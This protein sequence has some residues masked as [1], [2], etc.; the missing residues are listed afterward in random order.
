M[1]YMACIKGGADLFTRREFRFHWSEFV[2]NSFDG[3]FFSLAWA[4]YG[5]VT[6]ERPFLLTVLSIAS[7]TTEAHPT[8]PQ[9][10][11]YNP[12]ANSAV[13]NWAI[14]MKMLRMRPTQ[15]PLSPRGDRN[16]S[17]S[18]FMFLAVSAF[19]NRRWVM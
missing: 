1:T 10:P 5:P 2:E 15:V 11:Q 3:K 9:H 19:Q 4:G 8:Q 16:G 13:R 7:D 18:K 17:A 14:I 6:T 12:Q